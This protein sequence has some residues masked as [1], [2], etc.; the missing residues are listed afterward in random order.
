MLALG[1]PA[2]GEPFDAG[3]VLQHLALPGVWLERGRI[4]AADTALLGSPLG[5]A[6]QSVMGTLWC[7]AGSPFDATLREQLLDAA[8]AVAGGHAL[9]ATCG[10]TSPSA[11]VVVCRAL[12]P[13][14]EPLF[15]LW[16]AIRAVWRPLLWWLGAQPPRIWST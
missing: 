13:R 4:S 12:A 9:D 7:A 11:Q 1:L 16:R 6:G 10:A 14:V 3:S 8:R 5:L 2:A 15:E